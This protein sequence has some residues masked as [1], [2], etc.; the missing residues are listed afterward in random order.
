MSILVVKVYLMNESGF[1]M[2]VPS[3]YVK[4]KKKKKK[5]DKPKKL[6]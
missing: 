5:V 4:K 1:V 2:W 3:I 6:F